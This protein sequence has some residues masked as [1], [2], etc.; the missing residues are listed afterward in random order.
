MN[1]IVKLVRAYHF[2]AGHHMDQRRK[3]EAA[4][5]Y[6]N[7]LTEVAELVAEAT[8][9][10]EPE[11]IVAAI[12]HDVVED[13]PI[14]IEQVAAEFGEDVAA[15]VAQVTDDKSLPKAE[16]KRLQI[17]HAA[18][19]SSGA[20]I[21]KLADKTSNIRALANSPPADWPAERRQEYVAWAQ[22]VVAGCRGVN[23]WLERQFDEALA[24]HAPVTK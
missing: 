16:R 21:I 5:P 17:A 7:H 2:A 12:L 23:A 1:D 15:L 13:T 19:A 14:T 18:A 6:I 9:G 8:D 20:K 4:E 3:G 11:L 10:A 24:L 22:R